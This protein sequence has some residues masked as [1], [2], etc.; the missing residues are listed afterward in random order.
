MAACMCCGDHE[1]LEEIEQGGAT[2]CGICSRASR[3]TNGLRFAEATPQ[4][5]E[6]QLRGLKVHGLSNDQIVGIFW[7]E[8]GQVVRQILEELD[9]ECAA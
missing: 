6:A 1:P 3:F 4:G 9:K 2:L 5:A 8:Q 7:H